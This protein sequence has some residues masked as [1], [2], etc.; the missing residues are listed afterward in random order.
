MLYWID[1]RTFVD[2]GWCP[3]TYWLE[4]GLLVLIG[5]P[6]LR[7]LRSLGDCYAP[8]QLGQRRLDKLASSVALISSFALLIR[9]AGLRQML[10]SPSARCARGCA[11]ATSY[12]QLVYPQSSLCSLSFGFG[13][14]P[15]LASLP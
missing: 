1:S 9:R 13:Y 12:A 4:K 5:Q 10:A 7:S 3:S 14:H 6:R 2:L 8:P 11:A 15:N